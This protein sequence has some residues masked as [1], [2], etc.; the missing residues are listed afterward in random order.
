MTHAKLR[1]RTAK[2]KALES[3]SHYDASSDT[4][5]QIFANS[6]Y[7]VATIRKIA[8]WAGVAQGLVHYHFK[9]KDESFE[10]MITRHSKSIHRQQMHLLRALFEK[11]KTLSLEQSVQG[12]FRPTIEADLLQAGDGG[13]FECILVSTT[14]STGEPEQGITKKYCDPIAQEYIS[15]FVKINPFISTG[16]PTFTKYLN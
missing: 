2:K 5:E 10:A 14:N 12:L 15:A 13:T 9:T 8:E 7:R 1:S 3:K 11:K 4:L 6:G 16:A